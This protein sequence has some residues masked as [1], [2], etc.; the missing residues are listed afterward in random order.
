VRRAVRVSQR[1]SEIGTEQDPR[2]GRDGRL[3]CGSGTGMLFV[4]R[5]LSVR[6]LNVDVS[7]R[8]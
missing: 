2:N 7:V 4:S 3:R 1:S 6:E 8:A 5:E